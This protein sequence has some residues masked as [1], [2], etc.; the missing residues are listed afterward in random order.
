M[1]YSAWIH[2]LIDFPVSQSRVG[3]ESFILDVI[4]YVR[5]LSEVYE[6]TWL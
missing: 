6:N 4:H 5:E 2:V 3:R 1:L